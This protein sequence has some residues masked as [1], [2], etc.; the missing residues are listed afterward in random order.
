VTI[1]AAVSVVQK[2]GKTAEA[3]DEEDNHD[4]NDDDSELDCRAGA[5]SARH[6]ACHPRGIAQHVHDFFV[7]LGSVIHYQLR[8]FGLL[9][10]EFFRLCHLNERRL[11]PPVAAIITEHLTRLGVEELKILGAAFLTAYFY[12]RHGLNRSNQQRVQ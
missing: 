4:N 8:T 3:Q 1:V 5:A 12:G 11:Y 2:S 7:S 10:E 6:S 9:R